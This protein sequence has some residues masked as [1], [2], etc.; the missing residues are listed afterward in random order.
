[1]KKIDRYIL[2]KIKKQLNPN[3]VVVIYGSRQVGKTTLLNE[4][5]KTL[6]K[7]T[8]FVSGE[9][10]AT[11]E[12]LSSRSIAVLKKHIDEYQILII[13]EAQHIDQIGLNL[14]LIVDHIPNIRVIATGSSSFELANQIGEP[15][16]GR[17]WQ[18]EMFPIAQIE[19]K[20]YE[21][22]SLTIQ[23]LPERLIFGSYP[24]VITTSNLDEKKQLLNS[25]IDHYL[26]KDM[27]VLAELKKS[28]KIIDILKLLAFQIGQEVSISELANN[29]NINFATVE[30]YLDLLTKVFVI[31]RINGFSKNL[32]KEV[33]KNSRYYFY[34]NGIRNALINNFNDLKTRNDVGQLWEN[35]IILERI[36][37]RKYTQIFANQYFWRT[38]DQKEIDLVEERGG[39]LYGYECKWSALKVPKPPKEWLK[40][41]K[42]AKYQVIN[43]DNYLKFIT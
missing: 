39:Q 23:N 41:Y 28:Q 1:M 6:K 38:Y 16:V 22:Y 10:R 17:K 15:L 24:E 20:K 27:L 32:R 12:W 4:I 3:K 25:I 5:K 18:F 43:K 7:K 42:N 2:S 36:K 9:D 31:I 11:Q 26:F 21:D 19:L 30:R 8:L 29:L 40:T 35:Y 14:K 33:T 34:D 37:K 13:D